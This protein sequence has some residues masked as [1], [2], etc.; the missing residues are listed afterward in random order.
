LEGDARTTAGKRRQ[1]DVGRLVHQ[2]R[3]DLDWIMMK[4]LEKDRTR[5]YD[6]AN[7]LAADVQHY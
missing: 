7:A 4:C 6:T 3:G 2:L 1:T 5:R